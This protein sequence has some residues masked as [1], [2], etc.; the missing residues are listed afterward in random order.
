M[1]IHWDEAYIRQLY[2]DTQTP[3]SIDLEYKGSDSLLDPKK[4]KSAIYSELSKDV[5][6]FANAAGGILI[7]GIAESGSRAPRVPTDFDRGIDPQVLK[8]ETLEQV[9]NSHIKQRID[10][11]LIH[12]V[13]LDV[14]SPGM[15]SYVL[16]IPQATARAPHQA[17]DKKFYKR[18][19]FLAEAM[20]EY[21]VRDLYHRSTSPDLF[22]TI[23]LSPPVCPIPQYGPG[24]GRAAIGGI[25]L[26]L[27]IGNR[28]MQP[29][30]HA[31]IEVELSNGISPV[32]N[33][34]SW[35]TVGTSE[36]DVEGRA[37]QSVKLVHEF[38]FVQRL[39]LFEGYPQSLPP[40]SFNCYAFEA[41]FH[42][43]LEFF[44]RWTIRAPGMRPQSGIATLIAV[45]GQLSCKAP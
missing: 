2:I 39:P 14:A 20:E 11:L 8:K 25:V 30:S 19:N 1:Q 9:I 40:I 12:P 41:P 27:E 29:A 42:K 17:D 22:L 45:D 31:A 36:F 38:G 18:F 28:A 35:R 4:P 16:E 3:E 24:D 33:A 26:F 23:A 6:S 13:P 34:A 44:V 37:V 15:V 5:S 21:E 32:G 43:R 10:G 7:Y